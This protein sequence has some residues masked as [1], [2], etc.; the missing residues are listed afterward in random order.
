MTDKTQSPWEFACK[1]YTPPKTLQYLHEW[2]PDG[3]VP[4]DV[5]SEEFANWLTNQMRLAMSRGI[6]IG[7]QRR[8]EIDNT[9]TEG[10]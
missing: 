5:H 2:Q 4:E 6:M 3:N 7:E 10:K 8:A 9:T 1:A